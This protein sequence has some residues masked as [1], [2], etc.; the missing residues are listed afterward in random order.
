MT[1]LKYERWQTLRRAL[2]SQWILIAGT[3]RPVTLL[4]ACTAL[5]LLLELLAQSRIILFQ[6]GI[7]MPANWPRL[8]G[9][10]DFVAW[11]GLAWGI[12]IWAGEPPSKRDY[13]W[14]LPV[15]TVTHDLTRIIVGAAFLLLGVLWLCLLG[16]GVAWMTGGLPHIV[17]TPA[18]VWL[19]FPLQAILPYLLAAI[20]ATALERPIPALITGVLAFLV[21]TFIGA[22]ALPFARTPAILITE[23][24]G[25]FAAAKGP[26][27]SA[28]LPEHTA[29]WLVTGGW[30]TLLLGLLP[31]ASRTG[32]R[33]A[34][35]RRIRQARRPA[36]TPA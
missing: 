11:I 10:F 30:S 1:G 28:F 16:T 17:E 35:I 15:G 2:R 27:Q 33:R 18:V 19:A 5:L 7:P 6:P 12:A 25:L 22:A 34:M 23:P 13:H 20:L 29:N 3:K 14:S 24:Y 31:L 9:S 32:L 26:F 8:F 36:R 21:I 4:A